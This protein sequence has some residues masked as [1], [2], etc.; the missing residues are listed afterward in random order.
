[1]IARNINKSSINI[2][3]PLSRS[4]DKDV[5]VIIVD[6]FTKMIRLKITTMAMLLDKIT[7]IY[8][9]N[10]WKI[11]EVSKNYSDKELLQLKLK[12]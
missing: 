8:Q 10:I 1:M 5:I 11:Y 3:R 12:C 9:D 2:I 6:W 4:N 7:K